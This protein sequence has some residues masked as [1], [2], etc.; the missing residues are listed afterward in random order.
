MNKYCLI[1]GKVNV[2]KTLFFLNFAEYLGLKNMEVTFR[3]PSGRTFNKSYR[4]D[5]A[6]K[7]LVGM[8]KNK[9]LCLQ[10]VKIDVPVGKGKKKIDLVDTTGLVDGIH[11][12]NEVRRSMAQTIS[13]L[14]NADLILHIIDGAQIYQKEDFQLLDDIDYQIAQFAQLKGAYAIVVNKMDLSGAEEGLEKLQKEYIGYH[15]LPVSSL[16]KDG[17]KEVK[18][19]VW[20]NS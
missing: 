6:R 11:E 18:A 4:L 16:L 5:E 14:K 10:S 3:F 1:V 15:I 9:T 13:M 8:G 12:E 17:F 19:F 2:G 7:E 20:G